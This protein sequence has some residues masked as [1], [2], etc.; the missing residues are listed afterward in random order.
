MAL[1]GAVASAGPS[2][3]AAVCSFEVHEVASPG[4]SSAPGGGVSRTDPPG[5]ITCVGVI[6]GRRLSGHSG[7]IF[8]E[9]H[10]GTAMPAQ[11]MGGDS[12][13]VFS[14]LAD[15]T[16][17]LPTADGGDIRLVG[18][19]E[20]AG[21]AAGGVGRITAGKAAGNFVLEFRAEPDHLDEDCV[22]KPIQHFI[23]TGQGTLKG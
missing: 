7:T 12:C 20:A 16:V 2:N 5:V 17:T 14:G 13:V 8:Y 1:Q 11:A 19:L 18:I 9:Y 3:T 21:T 4:F 6:E 15:T 23:T 22:T 10:L